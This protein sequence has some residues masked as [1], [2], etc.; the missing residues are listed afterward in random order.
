MFLNQTTYP[1]GNRT[2]SVAVVDVNS[3]T[4]PDIIVANYNS[5]NVGVLVNNGSGT[6]LTQSTYATGA[7][8]RAVAVVDVNSDNK[9][10]IIVG[11][12]GSNTVSVL[13]HC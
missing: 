7:N 3:D 9:L 1:T 5:N 4:K 8:P 2:S 12:A 6:F 10:D 11:N 13:L